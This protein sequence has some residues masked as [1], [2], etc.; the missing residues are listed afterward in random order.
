MS[1]PPLVSIGDAYLLAGYAT[2]TNQS[3]EPLPA[4]LEPVRNVVVY[5]SDPGPGPTALQ[6]TPWCTDHKGVLYPLS[7][8]GDLRPTTVHHLGDSPAS[9]TRSRAG[10]SASPGRTGR[11]R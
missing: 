8:A 9:R 3:M 5:T 11:R 2:A 7:P 6:F 10:P 4:S 1:G